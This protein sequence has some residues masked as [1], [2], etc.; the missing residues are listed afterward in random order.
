[1]A[2]SSRF[3]PHQPAVFVEEGACLSVHVHNKATS[4]HQTHN[5]TWFIIS[6]SAEV[7]VEETANEFIRGDSGG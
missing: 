2:L 4:K 6:T 1:V 7:E 3:P 5:T